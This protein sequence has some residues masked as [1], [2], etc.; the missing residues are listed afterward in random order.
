MWRIKIAKIA[1]YAVTLLGLLVIIGWAFGI[2]WLKISSLYMISMKFLTAVSFV[3]SGIMLVLIAKSSANENS[4]GL[5]AI[6]LPI[7]SL[8]IMLIMLTSFF[9][10]IIGF[11][12]GIVNIFFREELGQPGT[13]YAIRPGLPSIVTVIS[14]V[15]IALSGL[16][17]SFT[18]YNKK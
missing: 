1:G 16:I 9:S 11:D 4:S 10:T 3:L 8:M 2:E 12:F 15:L 13:I 17:E 18:F 7:F 5:V 6:V 14:F